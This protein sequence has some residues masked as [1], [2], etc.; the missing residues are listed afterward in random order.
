MAESVHD[1]LGRVRP[2]RVHIRYDVETEAG[3]AQR[4]LPFVVGVMGDFSGNNPGEALKP[5]SDRKFVQIDRDNFDEVLAKMTPGVRLK[6]NNTLEGNNTELAVELKFKSMED[7]E[8][9]NIVKQ[10]E[11]LRKLLDARNKIKDLETRVDVSDK[12]E[13]LLEK[14]LQNQGDIEKLSKELGASGPA[15]GKGN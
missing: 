8:P 9:G 10:V 3:T 14:V 13:G 6:V 2:P 5:L 15:D 4:E 1:K 7:F 11:P 12:L